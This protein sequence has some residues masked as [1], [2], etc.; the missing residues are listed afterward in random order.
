MLKVNSQY[1]DPDEMSYEWGNNSE[2]MSSINEKKLAKTPPFI[3]P[4]NIPNH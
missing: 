2:A 4:A 3:I 1:C